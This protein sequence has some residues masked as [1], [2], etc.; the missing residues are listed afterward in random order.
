MKRG[1]HL[2]GFAS[3]RERSRD[4]SWERAAEG[5][6]SSEQCE[7]I[8]ESSIDPARRVPSIDGMTRPIRHSVL[9]AAIV[10]V[11][12]ASTDSASLNRDQNIVGSDFRL[13]HVSYFELF[14]VRQ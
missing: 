13:R 6:S 9:L 5:A 8:G 7:R 3:P 1:G 10:A 11:D 2:R 14:I 4:H 12:V